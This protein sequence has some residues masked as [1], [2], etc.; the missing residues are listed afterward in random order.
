MGDGPIPAR[1]ADRRRGLRLGPVRRP[2]GWSQAKA[3]VK[4]GYW[5]NAGTGQI[6]V[7][8]K[9][10]DRRPVC[11]LLATRHRMQLSVK[12]RSIT[13]SC[14]IEVLVKCTMFKWYWSNTGNDSTGQ[15]HLLFKVWHW[16]NVSNAGAVQTRPRPT[17]VGW[18]HRH[19]R[20]DPGPDSSAP[21]RARQPPHRPLPAEG[22]DAVPPA[23]WDRSNTGTGQMQAYHQ[24]VLF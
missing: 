24:G 14:Q 1:C 19:P 16:S 6:Q 4:H 13:G 5:S 17:Q 9:C 15:M 12:S 23:R 20:A 7:L 10:R 8:V 11:A 21:G 3:P 2:V 18:S 22:L